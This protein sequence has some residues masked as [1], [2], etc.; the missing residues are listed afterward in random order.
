MY[1]EYRK[2]YGIDAFE[3]LKRGIYRQHNNRAMC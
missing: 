3:G 2:G 1:G